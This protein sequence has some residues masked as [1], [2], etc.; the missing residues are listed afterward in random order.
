MPG[1]EPEDPVRPSIPAE[2]AFDQ[3]ARDR[4]APRQAERLILRA[5]EELLPPEPARILEL[6]SID[7]DV[8]R[9]GFRV[10]AD[11]DRGRERPW[12][13]GVVAHILHANSSLLENL[14][15]D[16][17]LEAFARLDETGEG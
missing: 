12:L 3:P 5:V 1:S 16:G 7:I 9:L 15:R 17:L 8:G 11:H 2:P 14:A 6:G 13:G 10:E 4:I